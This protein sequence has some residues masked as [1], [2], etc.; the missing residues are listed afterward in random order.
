MNKRI[1]T[2]VSLSILLLAGTIFFLHSCKKQDNPTKQDKDARNAQL[3]AIADKIAKSGHSFT[4]PVNLKLDA[5]YAD[6]LMHRIPKEIL[7]KRS[8][9][10]KGVNSISSACDFS[11]TPIVTISSYTITTNCEQ[12]FSIT[13]NYTISTNN[14]IVLTNPFIPTATSKG[15]LRIVNSSNTQIYSEN[16]ALATL[17]DAGADGSNP[18]YELYSLSVTSSS[19]TMS[20]FASGNSIKLGANLVTDCSD[21]EPISIAIA[22]YS[23][24]G[25]GGAATNPCDRIDEVWP[26]AFSAPVTVYGEDPIGTCQSGFVYPHVQEIQYSTDG[27]T[28]WIGES[29]GSTLSYIFPP[30]GTM[31]DNFVSAG[32]GYVDPYGVL[33]LKI[34]LP[35][36]HTYN[37]L[38]R[39]RNIMYNNTLASYGGTWPLPVFTGTGTNVCTG[40]WSVPTSSTVTY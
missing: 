1:L 2:S 11:N 18:G 7:M 30:T 36:G 15:L 25:A 37:L 21:V 39:H 32:L 20:D 33:E 13:W 29:A 23:L 26:S 14:N 12:G 34:T 22:T 35:A 6:S 38:L 27:G 28:T 9:S 24:N 19:I 17:Q 8:A 31:Y 10:T 16:P 40:A 4:I 5:Y 3:S